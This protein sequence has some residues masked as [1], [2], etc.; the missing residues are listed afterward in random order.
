MLG[1][2]ATGLPGLP[3]TAHASGFD[4]PTVGAVTSSPTTADPS[5]VH[6]NPAMLSGLD[7]LTIQSGLMLLGGDVRYTRDRR[8]A[9]QYEDGLELLS[10]V[11]PGALDPSKTGRAG[12]VSTQPI[13]PGGYFFMGG[14]VIPGRFW[15]GGGL[16]A[17]YA[18]V[19]DLPEDGPQRWQVVDA[20]LLVTKVSLA[21]AVRVHPRVSLGATVSYAGTLLEMYRVQDFAALDAISDALASPPINQDNG[22][23]ADA[24]PDVRELE[25]LSRPT[26]LR[27]TLGHSATFQAAVSVRAGR[28]LDLALHYEHGI[29]VRARGR[30]T[31][32]MDDPFFTD[33]LEAQGLDFPARVEGDATVRFTLPGRL[34]LGVGGPV[35]PRV[36]LDGVVSWARWSQLDAF[37][38]AL[39]SSDFEQPALGL[40]A[41]QRARIVRDFQDA[42]DL[43]VLATAEVAARETRRQ[44][45]I[46]VPRRPDAD[47]GRHHP[48][49]PSPPARPGLRPP[50]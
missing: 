18:A 4:V 32:D 17:P 28:A 31:I 43:R 22:L 11:A 38:L 34:T 49:R 10:P 1:A 37:D 13:A 19:L 23:G 25:T 9:Y 33:D 20:T 26:W 6:F 16:S 15:L 44:S 41:T 48:G 35:H 36:R 47:R 14:P 42:V 5:A 30:F 50:V 21:A 45:R 29:R 3:G 46:R 8:A 2:I 39:S 27:G 24:Q 12:T 7:R 40:G